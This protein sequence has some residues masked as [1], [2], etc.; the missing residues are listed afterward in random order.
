MRKWRNILSLMRSTRCPI[1]ENIKNKDDNY[2]LNM[3][4]SR[5][6]INLLRPC[7]RDHIYFNL[8]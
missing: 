3:V 1:D 8:I 6:S 4:E 2:V 7:V 5:E